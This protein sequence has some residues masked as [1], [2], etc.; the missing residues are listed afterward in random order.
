LATFASVVR[1]AMH[2]TT[3][4]AATLNEPTVTARFV[5]AAGEAGL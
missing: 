3:R 1:V 5:P 2:D 4:T